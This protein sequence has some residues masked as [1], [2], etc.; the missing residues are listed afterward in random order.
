VTVLALADAAGDADRFKGA[1]IGQIQIIGIDEIGRVAQ[2]AAQRDGEAARGRA[3]TAAGFRD[4]ARKADVA[5]PVGRFGQLAQE[6]ARCLERAMHVPQ[7][8]GAAEAGEL[9]TRGRMALGDRARLID[10]DEEEGDPLG[11]RTLQRG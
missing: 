2:F 10:A 4:I 9:Q 11:A 6:T 3:K 8:A 5:H 1:R 7:G